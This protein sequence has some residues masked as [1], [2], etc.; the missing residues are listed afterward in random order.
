MTYTCEIIIDASIEKVTKLY[1][2]RQNMSLWEKGLDAIEDIKGY[3]FDTG[4]EGYLVFVFDDQTMK[5]KVTVENNRLPEQIIQIFEVSGAWNRCDNKFFQ[6]R[7]GTK[8]IM[9]VTFIFDQEP[10]IPKERFIEKTLAG[11]NQFKRFVE[12]MRLP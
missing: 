3:L 12:G 11:M 2:D 5:M 10:H 7:D 6:Y 9:D 8:W 4:S 1:I